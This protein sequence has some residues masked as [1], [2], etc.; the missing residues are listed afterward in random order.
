MYYYRL[1][2]K[3]GFKKKKFPCRETP[4]TGKVLLKIA[5]LVGNSIAYLLGMKWQANNS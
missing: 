1:Q 3:L 5:G 4:Q 2:N